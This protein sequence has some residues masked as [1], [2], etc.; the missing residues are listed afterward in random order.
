MFKLFGWSR[1]HYEDINR[2]YKMH[3]EKDYKRT[4]RHGW[5]AWPGWN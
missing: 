5:P 2:K 4:I 3:E 1:R